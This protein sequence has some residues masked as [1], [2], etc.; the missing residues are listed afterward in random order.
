MWKS[1]SSGFDLTWETPFY[2]HLLTLDFEWKHRGGMTLYFVGHRSNAVCSALPTHHRQKRLIP[3]RK[4]EVPSI[5]LIRVSWDNRNNPLYWN[6]IRKTNPLNLLNTPHWGKGTTVP[7]GPITEE[8]TQHCGGDG[9][10]PSLDLVC[11]PRYQ[12]T[13]KSQLSQGLQ[14]GINFTLDVANLNYRL[15]TSN[16]LPD[17]AL[18]L[19]IYSPHSPIPHFYSWLNP[20]A[21]LNSD[22]SVGLWQISNRFVIQFQQRWPLDF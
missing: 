6:H 16:H 8:A 2:K 1:G 7:P 21:L 5:H 13:V 19:H 15:F 17:L 4:T 12:Q 18:P 9:L 3:K 22:S 14:F 20:E 10:Y 11:A